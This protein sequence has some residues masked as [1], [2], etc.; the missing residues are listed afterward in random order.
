MDAIAQWLNIPTEHHL[1]LAML[2]STLALVLAGVFF[3]YGISYSYSHSP[4]RKDTA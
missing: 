2:I 3:L 4:E 1:S